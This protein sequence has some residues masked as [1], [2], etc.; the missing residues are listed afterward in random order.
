[1]TADLML[2]ALEQAVL[3]RQPGAGLVHLR[4]K[5]SI[6]ILNVIKRMNKQSLV[7]LSMWR[8]FTIASTAIQQ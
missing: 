3:H 6:F 1:M 4:L 5:L 2:A 7:F 8:F